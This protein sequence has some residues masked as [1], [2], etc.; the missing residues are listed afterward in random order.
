MVADD[1]RRHNS[2]QER[3][4]ARVVVLWTN[5]C[6]EKTGHQTITNISEKHFNV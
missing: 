3:L 5:N 1:Q 2:N 6:R 4:T